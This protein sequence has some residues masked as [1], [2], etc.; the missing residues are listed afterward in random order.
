MPKRANGNAVQSWLHDQSRTTAQKILT[1]LNE[2][3]RN[4]LSDI[5]PQLASAIHHQALQD[6]LTTVSL[7]HAACEGKVTYKLAEP[8][9]LERFRNTLRNYTKEKRKPRGTKNTKD[10]A[11][12]QESSTPPSAQI[13]ELPGMGTT[14]STSAS[15]Y[16]G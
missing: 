12:S 3:L 5:P 15:P 1:A 9:E 2:E 6:A 13:D 10:T 8:E 7:I 11:N 14:E 16:S 4:E